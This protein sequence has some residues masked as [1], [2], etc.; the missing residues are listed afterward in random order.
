MSLTPPE[1]QLAASLPGAV[2]V[3]DPRAS[4]MSPSAVRSHENPSAQSMAADRMASYRAP[5]V[6]RDIA[7]VA[8]A[9]GSPAVA[10]RPVRPSRMESLIPPTS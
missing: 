10:S 6:T 4:R 5:S 7:W 8:S 2:S 3:A 1:P 9:N